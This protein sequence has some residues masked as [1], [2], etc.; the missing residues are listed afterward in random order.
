MPTYF[1]YTTI[2][3]GYSDIL[4]DNWVWFRNKTLTTGFD[5]PGSG[6]QTVVSLGLHAKSGGGTPGNVRIAIYTAAHS[7]IAQ[8]SAEI[9]VNSVTHQWWEHTAFVDS[10]GSPI[11]PVLTGGVQYDLVFGGDSNDVYIA[12]DFGSSGDYTCGPTDYT[13]GFPAT[14]NDGD[15]TVWLVNIRCGVD[16][17]GGGLSIPVAM[18]YRRMMGRN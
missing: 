17:A 13:G 1:G 14:L 11:S 18:H 3:G 2:G 6:N 7:L 15:N 12:R 5:C 10:G 4:V 8:G 9:S 16:P